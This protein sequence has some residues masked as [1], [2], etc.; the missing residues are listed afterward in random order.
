MDWEEADYPALGNSSANHKVKF[1]SFP[2]L[3]HSFVFIQF[4]CAFLSNQ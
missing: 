4:S 2:P 1:P 3:F